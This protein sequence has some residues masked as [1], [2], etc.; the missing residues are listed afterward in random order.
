MD[1]SIL[2]LGAQGAG[3]TVYLAG[4]YQQLSI[5]NIDNVV[6]LETRERYARRLFNT[7]LHLL[8]VSREFPRRP[9]GVWN[10]C[11]STVC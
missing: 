11:R 9:P 1:I 6:T 8:D 7:Y 4:L 10:R 2:V 5:A 3:K